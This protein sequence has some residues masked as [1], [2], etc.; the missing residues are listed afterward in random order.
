VQDEPPAVRAELVASRMNRHG[1][2]VGQLW[3]D[4]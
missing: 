2:T 1:S 4:V 3:E